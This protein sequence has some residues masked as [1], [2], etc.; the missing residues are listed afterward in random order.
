MDLVVILE[1]GTLPDEVAAHFEALMKH[2]V[3]RVIAGA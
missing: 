2:G 3:L 1:G